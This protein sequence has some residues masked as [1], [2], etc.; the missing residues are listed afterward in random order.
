M[1][2]TVLSLDTSSSSTGWALFRN[3]IYQSSG[4]IDLK[5]IKDSPTRMRCMVSELHNL[6]DDKSNI[7]IAI[8]TP[9]VVRNPHT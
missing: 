9:V 1:D 6:L 5:H 3:G 8:E 2:T 7:T 4:V